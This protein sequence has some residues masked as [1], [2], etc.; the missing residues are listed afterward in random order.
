MSAI[1]KS[2]VFIQDCLDLMLL[3]LK[4]HANAGR[5]VNM[6]NWTNAFAFDVVGELTYGEQLVHPRTETDLNGLRKAIFD[7][8]GVMSSFS[9]FVGQSRLVNIKLVNSVMQALGAPNP[10]VG[11][12][13]WTTRRIEDRINNP[14]SNPGEDL[15]SHFVRM[16]TD[17]GEPASFNEVLIEA[18][19]IIYV[20]HPMQE[21]LCWLLTL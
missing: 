14:D 11:F 8:F 4:K 18:M 10:F 19:N 2:E 7:G 15:L 21:L 12:Q 17:K 1:L 3:R 20:S 16:K 9:H 6:A 5:T 13:T